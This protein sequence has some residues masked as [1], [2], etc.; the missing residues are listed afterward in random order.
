MANSLRSHQ[1]DVYGAWLHLATTEQAWR[2]LRRRLPSL[3]KEPPDSQGAVSFTVETSENGKHTAHLP[4]WLN[5]TAV[6]AQAE[7]V[8]L[9]AHE[10]THAAA[11]LL[12]HIGQ[13]YDG[14]SEALAYL[15]GFIAAWLW[16]GCMT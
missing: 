13:E 1:L 14:G 4:I 6:D 9:I 5:T 12:D 11:A 7:L 15:V 3:D 8:D 10:S 16:D 2:K